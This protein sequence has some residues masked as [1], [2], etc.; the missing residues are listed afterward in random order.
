MFKVAAS[1]Q[2][3]SEEIAADLLVFEVEEKS[4]YVACPQSAP[5]KTPQHLPESKYAPRS[6]V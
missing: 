4:N 6:Y 2:T 1:E 3:D 5:K